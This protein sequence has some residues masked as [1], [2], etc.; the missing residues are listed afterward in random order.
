MSTNVAVSPGQI[1]GQTGTAVIRPR[2]SNS[3]WHDSWKRLKKNRSAVVSG[4]FIVAVLVMAAC[5]ELI[6]VHSF[7]VQYP[8]R[9]LASPSLQHW[10][11]TDDLGRDLY[12]RLVFGAR[13]SMI[14]ALVAALIAFVLGTALGAL[15]G[16]VGGRTDDFIMRSID[17]VDS[18]PSMVLLI[19]VKILFDSFDFIQSPEIRALTGMILALSVFG[20]IMLARVVRGQVLQVK[21]SLYVEAARSL[22]AG[23]FSILRRHIFPNILGPIIVVLTFQIPQFILFESILSFIG[24]GLQPPFSSWGVL[25][26]TGWKT[27]KT[28][29]HLIFAPSLLLFL[30]MLAFN[31]LG[32]GLR[33]AFDPKMRGKM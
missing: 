19:L 11:G 6:T 32:D 29:P 27:I 33:D 24:L 14:V 10:L 7:E 1:A 5:A 15:S 13:M 9:I 31:L 4:W 18:I 25:A 17:I 26:N 2:N 22:G 28:Y 3:L 20:W 8:D 23:W 16:W 12:S 30:T 21:E